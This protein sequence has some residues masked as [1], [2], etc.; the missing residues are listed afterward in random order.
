[1]CLAIEPMLTL[2]DRFTEVC[3]DDWTVVTDDGARAAHWEH[4]VAILDEGIWVLT[5]PDGGAAELAELGVR[6]APWRPDALYP[7]GT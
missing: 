6:V 4:S 1:M 5:A 2:G 7:P 3:E